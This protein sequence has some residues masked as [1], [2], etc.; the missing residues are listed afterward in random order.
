MKY[1]WSLTSTGQI[2]NHVFPYEG[3]FT[4]GLLLVSVT[5]F[6]VAYVY[7]VHNLRISC[8]TCELKFEDICIYNIGCLHPVACTRSG[9]GFP[10]NATLV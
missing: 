8:N 6:K 1:C 7:L 10:S 4:S 3:V 5:E 9:S 2:R